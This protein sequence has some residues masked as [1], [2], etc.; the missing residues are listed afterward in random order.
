MQNTVQSCTNKY[1]RF[2]M[3]TAISACLPSLIGK[4]YLHCFG[5]MASESM[6][7]SKVSNQHC[8]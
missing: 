7:M 8:T 1:G 4:V 6:Q 2:D 5:K 3:C